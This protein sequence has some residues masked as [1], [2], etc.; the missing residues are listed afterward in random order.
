MVL[1][2]ASSAAGLFVQIDGAQQRAFSEQIKL[3]NFQELAI[4]WIS[5][6]RDVNRSGIRIPRMIDT[7][8]VWSPVWLIRSSMTTVW[9]FAW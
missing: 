2:L 3:D 9:P 6:F 5:S 7:S 4:S 1:I 8:V